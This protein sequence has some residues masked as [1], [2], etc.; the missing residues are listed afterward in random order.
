MFIK[1]WQRHEKPQ[2]EKLNGDK[3][4]TVLPNTAPVI[5]IRIHA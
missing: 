4:V 3:K 2:I 5:V 1:K